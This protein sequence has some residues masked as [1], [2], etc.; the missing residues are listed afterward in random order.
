[1]PTFC[2]K[3]HD[4]KVLNKVQKEDK[5]KVKSISLHAIQYYHKKYQYT[6]VLSEKSISFFLQGIVSNIQYQHSFNPSS[7]FIKKVKR[8]EGKKLYAQLYYF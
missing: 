6:V 8:K 4:T 5:S 1:M 3:I 7:L 2:K